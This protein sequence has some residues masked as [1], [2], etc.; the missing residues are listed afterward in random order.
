VETVAE[1]NLRAFLERLGEQY[2]GSAT[3]YLLG[4]GAL[5]PLGSPCVI[6]DIDYWYATAFEEKARLRASVERLVEEIPL[7]V[8]DIPLDGSTASYQLRICVISCLHVT[9]W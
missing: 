9:G 3:L 4:G 2:Q 7:D 8:E 5:C 6:V 1:A